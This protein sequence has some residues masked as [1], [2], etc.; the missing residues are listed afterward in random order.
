MRASR[1]QF[2]V[3][4]FQQKERAFAWHF[5]GNRQLLCLETAAP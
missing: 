2:P 4:S 5:S 1:F 3:S